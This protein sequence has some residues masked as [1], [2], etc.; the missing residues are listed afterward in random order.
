[1]KKNRV[2]LLHPDWT[3]WNMSPSNYGVMVVLLFFVGLCGVLLGFVVDPW[4]FLTCPPTTFFLLRG[5]L[6]LTH[7][8]YGLKDEKKSLY[9]AYWELSAESRN[10]LPRLT[11]EKIRQMSSDACISLRD[12]LNDLRLVE[13]RKQVAENA[14]DPFPSDMVQASREL[15]KQLAQEAHELSKLKDE[16][17]GK[18]AVPVIRLH[19]EGC[20]CRRCDMHGRWNR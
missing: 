18:A 8:S 17:Q 3:P 7:E 4:Y 15:Q 9:V 13:K 10:T 2:K 1:V 5:L 14:L 12:E 11:G 16:L 20:Y 6:S 19:E